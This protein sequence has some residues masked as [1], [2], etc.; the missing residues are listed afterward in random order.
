MFWRKKKVT[1]KTD[2]LKLGKILHELVMKEAFGFLDQK[3]GKETLKSFGLDREGLGD[4]LIWLGQFAAW[5]VLKKSFPDGNED[6]M[7]AMQQAYYDE[8]TRG[9]VGKSDITKLDSYLQKRV[10]ALSVAE[11]KLSDNEFNEELGKMSAISASQSDLPPEGLSNILLIYYNT[12]S[13]SIAEFLSGVQIEGV[14]KDTLD[15]VTAGLS[16]DIF[17][18]AISCADSVEKFQKKEAEAK[19]EIDSLQYRQLA[20]EFMFLFIHLSDRIA[21]GLLGSEKRSRFM[22]LLAFWT[23]KVISEDIA[24]Y[25]SSKF[26]TAVQIAP[27]ISFVGFGHEQLNERNIEYG[28]YKKLFPEK[29]E[30]Y[31]NTPFWEFGKHVSKIVAGQPNDIAYMMLAI[32]LAINSIKNLSIHRKLQEI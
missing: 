15:E 4:E 1:G 5:S 27:K 12:V 18:E 22:N 26:K 29:N 30:D 7:A 31:K 24:P 17:K 19:S 14:K 8:L 13:Y 10:L 3:V 20:I 6:V 25:I 9:G 16:A 32:E 21:F 11:T 28:K 2:P 23:N